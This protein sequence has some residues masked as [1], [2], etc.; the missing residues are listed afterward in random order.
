MKI[1]INGEEKF[2]DK[3]INL[4]ILIQKQLDGKDTKGIA[5]AV[6]Y[7]IVPK[8]KWESVAINENDAVEIVHAVQGG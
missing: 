5:V 8:Q 7:T 2:L 3:Q 6:N 1:K 4:S